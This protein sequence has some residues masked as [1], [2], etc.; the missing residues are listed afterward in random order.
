MKTKGKL[1]VISGPSGVGKGTIC[2]I[3][4]R[5]CPN[6]ILSVSA[7]TR[8]PRTVDKEGV[9]YYFKTN[10]EFQAMIDN[11][12]FLEWAV[13]NGNYYGTPL[14]PVQ[15]K[16]NAGKNVLLE[17]DVQGA[18]HVKDNFPEGIYIFIAPPDKETLHERLTGRGTESPEEISRRIAAADQELAQQSKYDYVVINDVL[19][20][21]VQTVKDII[22]TR[23]VA[24]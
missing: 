10:Q 6:L 1:I 11:H 4:L 19:E 22:E 24:V 14:L 12:Q 16:L 13:Y 5:Q 20:N 23:S 2:E 18:L 8:K 15:E 17:I 3:L 9:T 21:A 7:T